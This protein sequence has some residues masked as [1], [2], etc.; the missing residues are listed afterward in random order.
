MTRSGPAQQQSERQILAAVMWGQLLFM[1]GHSLTSPSGGFL[2]YFFYEF[3]PSALA[4]AL[5]KTLPDV[6][7]LAGLAASPLARWI[8][9][10]KHLW[11]GGLLA[12]RCIS[13]L[14][15]LNNG[16]QGEPGSELRPPAIG[17]VSGFLIVLTVWHLLQAV[18]FMAYL[19]W[20]GSLLPDQRWGRLFA[21]R[22]LGGLLVLLIVPLGAAQLK[23]QVLNPLSPMAELWGYTLVHWTGNALCLLSMIPLL[24]LPADAAPRVLEVPGGSCLLRGFRRMQRVWGDRSYRLLLLH[25]W[26]LA[27]FQGLTQ[28]VLWQFRV[29]VLHISL[30]TYLLLDASMVLLQIPFGIWGG[31]LCDSGREWSAYFW[32]V[33]AVSSALLFYLAATPQTWWLLFVAHAVFGVFG[34]VNVCVDTVG[35][36]LAP[37]QDNLLHLATFRQGGS[38][39]AGLAGLLGGYWLD[40]L[41]ADGLWGLQ[42]VEAGSRL[43]MMVSWM[44]RLTAACWLLPLWWQQLRRDQA[45]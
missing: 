23:D 21:R 14:I 31:R 3:G 42:G 40:R 19:S 7:G 25:G 37:R 8:G 26:W 2:T 5:L 24:R 45:A 27:F 10:R 15:P 32:G 18:A 16:W 38:L 39:L 36:K 30:S 35:L 41:T 6:A 12:A 4:V 28:A 34:L 44:G 20:L 9:S 33:L 22:Q 13:L 11:L 1:A 17:G 43:L 29:K